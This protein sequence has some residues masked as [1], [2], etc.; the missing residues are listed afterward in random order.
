MTDQAQTTTLD[1]RIKQAIS[2]L[3]SAE[4]NGE[5]SLLN[6]PIPYPSGALV[7][8]EIVPNAG[9]YFVSDVG[10]GFQEAEAYG[11][12]GFYSHSAKQ[13]AQ[14]FGVSFDGYS[15]FSQWVGDSG[16]E[17]ALV[18]VANAS[19]NAAER[20]IERAIEEKSSQKTDELFDRV[21]KIF[22]PKM[23]RRKL[24]IPGR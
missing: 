22:G 5:G 23:V 21:E 9:S 10:F 1:A 24:E 6:M 19:K 11:A 20:A 2:N 17:S 7:V 14:K 4:Q 18:Y 12:Q 8:L 15:I 13:A 16:L 3:L